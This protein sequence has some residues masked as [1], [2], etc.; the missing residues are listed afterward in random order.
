[1][2]HRVSKGGKSTCAV[3]DKVCGT[4]PLESTRERKQHRSAEDRPFGPGHASLRPVEDLSQLMRIG[5]PRMRPNL[6]HRRLP[7]PISYR[8]TRPR[9]II[10]VRFTP[11]S[12][13]PCPT[14]PAGKLG[15]YG[16]GLKPRV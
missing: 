8:Q 3:W 4:N 9:T 5:L 13:D 16:I 12:W 14:F 2:V 10:C 15:V 1:M 7:T 11:I 6:E